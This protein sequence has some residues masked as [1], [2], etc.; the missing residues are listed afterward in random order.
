MV[1]SGAAE[2]LP[3]W[4]Q[5]REPRRDRASLVTE[6]RGVGSVLAIELERVIRERTRQLRI[7]FGL[8]HGLRAR[9]PDLRELEGRELGRIGVLVGARQLGECGGGIAVLEQCFA[10]LVVLRD[11]VRVVRV[12]LREDL[13]RLGEGLA[14]LGDGGGGTVVLA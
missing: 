5:G 4:R 9:E 11:D 2:A 12:E 1:R 7:S 8:H 6:A 14:M 10:Q 3:S 13:D